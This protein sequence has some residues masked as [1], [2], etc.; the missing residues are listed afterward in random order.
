MNW[1]LMHKC[2][3]PDRKVWPHVILILMITCQF[4]ALGAVLL[5]LEPH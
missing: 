4:Y 1:D 5:V 3:H 2:Y